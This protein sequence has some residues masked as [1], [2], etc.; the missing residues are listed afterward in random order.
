MASACPSLFA[1]DSP[2]EIS[3]AHRAEGLD[4]SREA[5]IRARG[6]LGGRG[7]RGGFPIRPWGHTGPRLSFGVVD[8][9]RGDFEPVGGERSDAAECPGQAT[10]GRPDQTKPGS[11]SFR[12]GGIRCITDGSGFSRSL[13]FCLRC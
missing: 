6:R 11:E 10:T 13:R 5:T 1:D 9:V 8:R 7:E 3:P 2:L 4:G 12:R